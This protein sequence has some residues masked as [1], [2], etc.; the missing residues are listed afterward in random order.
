MA[1]MPRAPNAGPITGDE[2]L[3]MIQEG[4][5]VLAK[6]G[7]LLGAGPAGEPGPQGP[8]GD[9]GPAGSRGATGAKGDAGPQGIQGTV[10]PAGP[11]GDPGTPL[12]VEPYTVTS[13]AS[14]VATFTFSPAFTVINDISVK[15]GWVNDQQVGGGV[16]S[17]TLT[18]ATVLVK[19][20]RGAL[21]LTTGPF[22]TAPNTPVSI[23]VTGR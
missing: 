9:I 1:S 18:G 16:T 3:R 5:P 4:K 23:V 22:E 6:S 8:Q 21:L 12:R 7:D 2:R 13:N 14:G 11:K 20:S 19:R 17:Q 15:T 10:G